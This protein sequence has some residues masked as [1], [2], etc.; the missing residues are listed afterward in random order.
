MRSRR[1]VTGRFRSAA[2]LATTVLAASTT[3]FGAAPAHAAFPGL[4]RPL[5]FERSGNLFTA[6]GSGTAYTER[7]LDDGGSCVSAPV[8]SRCSF[9]PRPDGWGSLDV[10]PLT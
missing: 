1:F 10:Q 8:T 6:T 9:H 4:D 7:P 5:L 2:L 3:G